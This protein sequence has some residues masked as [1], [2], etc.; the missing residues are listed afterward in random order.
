MLLDN[1]YVIRRKSHDKEDSKQTRKFWNFTKNYAKKTKQSVE[2]ELFQGHLGKLLIKENDLITSLASMLCESNRKLRQ[3]H[4][5]LLQGLPDVMENYIHKERGKVL[6]MLGEAFVVKECQEIRQYLIYWNQEYNG[7][8]YNLPPVRI[9]NSTLKFLEI[10]S[11]RLTQEAHKIDCASRPQELYVKDVYGQFWRYSRTSN[12][13]RIVLATQ[14]YHHGELKLPKLAEFNEKLIHYEK[15][16]PSRLHL[17]HLLAAQQRNLQELEDMRTVGDGSIIEG[18]SHGISHVLTTLTKSGIKL[19]RSIA[20]G[21]NGV[22]N[23]TASVVGNAIHGLGHILSFTNGLSGLILYIID[24]LIIGYLVANRIWEHRAQRVHL[25]RQQRIDQE[26]RKIN[27]RE[28]FSETRP[29]PVPPHT[30]AV[31]GDI[32]EH[33]V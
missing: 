15:S 12:F 29:P 3:M 7:T 4:R 24:F 11:R 8:C 28:Q 13:S 30:G 2:R 31:S 18:I 17:L 10:V 22:T 20:K 33:R 6:S 32:P 23:E 14:K 1:T 16:Q 25:V 5:V 26:I 19:V 9:Q 27:L 21:I